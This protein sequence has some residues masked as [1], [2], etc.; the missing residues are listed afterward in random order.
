MSRSSGT[1]SDEQYNNNLLVVDEKKRKVNSQSFKTELS[2][3]NSGPKPNYAEKL[4]PVVN[5]LWQKFVALITAQNITYA[6]INQSTTENKLL[7]ILKNNLD[8]QPGNTIQEQIESLFKSIDVDND[9]SI[10]FIELMDFY[11]FKDSNEEMKKSTKHFFSNIDANH[12]DKLSLEEF[13][14]ALT[15]DRSQKAILYGQLDN[16]LQPLLDSTEDKQKITYEN[17]TELLRV[18]NSKT[19]KVAQLTTNS[20]RALIAEINK[21]PFISNVQK[22]YLDSLNDMTLERLEQEQTF[23]AIA[24]SYCDHLFNRADNLETDNE[25]CILKDYLLFKCSTFERETKNTT[26][27]SGSYETSLVKRY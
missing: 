25:D 13:G 7:N 21:Y 24:S 26:L 17:L 22:A 16:L 12:D 11:R 27:V 10:S 1:I 18:L 9:G 6:S 8:L 20:K 2:K 14:S 3:G 15:E 19:S 4:A 23:L 5:S